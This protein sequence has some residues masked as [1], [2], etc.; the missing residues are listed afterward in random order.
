MLPDVQ[1]KTLAGNGI[2]M[3]RA[4]STVSVRRPVELTQVQ[5]T[6]GTIDRALIQQHTVAIRTVQKTAE[7]LQRQQ[8]DRVVD[9]AVLIQ[10]TYSKR[11][12]SGKLGG[13]GAKG[14]SRHHEDRASRRRPMNV[15]VRTRMTDSRRQNPSSRGRLLPGMASSWGVREAPLGLWCVWAAPPE[16]KRLDENSSRAVAK[17]HW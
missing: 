2:V 9:V 13:A 7:V 4:G 1:K 12:P 5:H 6:E 10:P 8:L 17:P 14:F 15:Q 11:S 3:A 16:S